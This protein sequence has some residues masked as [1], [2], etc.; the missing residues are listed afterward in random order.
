[1]SWSYSG[2]PS[3]SDLDRVRFL[4]GDTDIDDKL[5]SN[6]E[7]NYVIDQHGIPSAAYRVAQNLV[8]KFS[9]FVDESVG[10]VK[11][12]F[13]QRVKHYNELAVR[14]KKEASESALPYAGGISISDKEVVEQD[15]DRSI[16]IFTRNMLK[17]E[18]VDPRKN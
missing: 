6:E 15:G 10:A 9:R 3:K 11:I 5:F 13:S 16:P 4:V 2:D 1:M 18:F 12:T 17:N 7:I 14:L 8:A